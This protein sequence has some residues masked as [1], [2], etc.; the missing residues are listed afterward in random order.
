LMAVL[1]AIAVVILSL[2]VV[3]FDW[4]HRKWLLR[5]ARRDSPLPE[6]SLGVPR[7]D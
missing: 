2:L 6:F 1:V 4:R 5:R 7:V 3:L